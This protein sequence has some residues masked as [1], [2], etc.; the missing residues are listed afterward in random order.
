MG[1]G[2]SRFEPRH[3]EVFVGGDFDVGQ[4]R[5]VRDFRQAL[6]EFDTELSSWGDDQEIAEV[7]V[8]NGK[9]QVTLK[10]GVVQ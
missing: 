1:D 5:T 2:S 10:D 3:V 6:R 9:I 4:P 7:H 8:H